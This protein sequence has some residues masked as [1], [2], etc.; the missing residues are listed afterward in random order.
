VSSADQFVRR[1]GRAR[2]SDG[3]LLVWSV[4]EGHRGRRW[5]ATIR[6]ADSGIESVL[7]LELDLDGAST[8]LELAASGGM[9]TLHPETDQR[10][11]HGNVVSDDGVRPIALPWSPDGSTHVIGHPITAA[12]LAHRL[13]GSL[14]VGAAVDV[15]IVAVE[16]NLMTGVT[17]CRVRREAGDRWA[18]DCGDHQMD[19]TLDEVGIPHFEG[20]AGEW[21]LEE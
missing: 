18:L 15:P 3:R 11:V 1:A 14:A 4:A 2:L 10:S 5:R 8:R 17:V 6:G 9:L 16:Q 19:I 21:P 13:A 20:H 12:A 7:V